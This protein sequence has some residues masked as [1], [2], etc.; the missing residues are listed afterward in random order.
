M[1]DLSPNRFARGSSSRNGSVLIVVL[2]CLSFAGTV[3]LG[4]LRTSLQ[5]RRQL[6]NEH[7]SVQT[8]WLLDAGVRLAIGQLQRDESYSGQTAKFEEGLRDG[9]VGVVEIV[10]SRGSESNERQLVQVNAKLRRPGGRFGIQRS[11]DF[12][13]PL[14][15]SLSPVLEKQPEQDP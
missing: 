10:V 11:L 15:N 2:V 12:Q 1:R 14:T 7:D 4:A 5:Q 9:Q 3:L 13:I 8:E 6:R